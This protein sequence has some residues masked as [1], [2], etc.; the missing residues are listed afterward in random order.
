MIVG[1]FGILLTLMFWSTWGGFHHRTV[2][3]ERD[4]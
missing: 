3:H 1:A 4:A 2:V